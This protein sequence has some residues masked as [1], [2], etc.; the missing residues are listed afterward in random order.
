MRLRE[1][2]AGG[3]WMRALPEKVESLGHRCHQRGWVESSR[4]TAARSNFAETARRVSWKSGTSIPL[5]KW[6]GASTGDVIRPDP[7]VVFP[8]EQCG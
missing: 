1:N 8:G 7:C 5:K 4:W 2:A 6:H 3:I